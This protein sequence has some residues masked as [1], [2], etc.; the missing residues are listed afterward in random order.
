MTILDEIFAYKRTEVAERQRIRPL[1]QVRAGA[2]AQAQALD[3]V[4]ALRG[5]AQ[6]AKMEKGSGVALIAEVKHASPSR[7][8]LVKDFDPLR[9]ARTY[10]ENGA[11]ALSV[12]TDERYFQGHLD[13]LRQ[14][15][16]VHARTPLLRKDFLYD[17][18]Q[19]YEAREAG[20]DAVLLIAASLDPELLRDLHSLAASLGMAALVEVHSQEELEAV[21]PLGPQLVGIN[22][23]DLRDFS[24]RLE[25]TLDL[26]PQVPLQV[27]VVA[28]S[29][30]HTSSD[31]ERLA[32]AGIDAILVGEG[33]V[34]APDVA[35][36]VR[37]LAGKQQSAPA[38]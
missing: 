35:A 3:F 18:Y 14:I 16:A 25:T 11:A 24:V 31:V 5:A 6:G 4:S 8:V 37:L 23:R 15:R 20:A 36:K 10:V 38:Q 33:L 32:Q 2:E 13:Y 29:G 27:C 34:T 12:L 21:L 22:N 1:A 17:P 30:I 9:L 7:G 19:V 26:R 28:E